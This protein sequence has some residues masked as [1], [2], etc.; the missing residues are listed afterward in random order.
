MEYISLAYTLRRHTAEIE[1]LVSD[2]IAALLYARSIK[3]LR[4]IDVSKQLNMAGPGK[5]IWLQS[6]ETHWWKINRRVSSDGVENVELEN[7]RETSGAM[8]RDT[9][10]ESELEI[11]KE[12][13]HAF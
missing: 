6:E 9:Y 5:G 12:R 1:N 4:F 11:L 3:S 13:W 8:V 2:E 10:D 7:L